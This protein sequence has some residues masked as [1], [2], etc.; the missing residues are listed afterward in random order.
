MDDDVYSSIINDDSDID[1][2]YFPRSVPEG[3]SD[4]P[5]NKTAPKKIRIRVNG[6]TYTRGNVHP[7]GS[8]DVRVRPRPYTHDGKD[9]RTRRFRGKARHSRAVHE[10]FWP[11]K[12][13]FETVKADLARMADKED[14]FY[15]FTQEWDRMHNCGS[16][17]FTSMDG[18]VDTFGPETARKIYMFI[19]ATNG[20][21]RSHFNHFRK[22]WEDVWRKQNSQNIGRKSLY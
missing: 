7:R 5:E 6:D 1:E 4:K 18:F 11:P 14:V 16:N 10:K 9:R 20:T 12:E 8:D 2:L 21:L 15:R 22:D 3:E 19:I 17:T 13:F